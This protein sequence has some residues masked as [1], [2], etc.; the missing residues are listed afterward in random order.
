MNKIKKSF[1]KN[2][3]YY[4]NDKGERVIRHYN[5][6]VIT[7]TNECI[8]LNDANYSMTTRKLVNMVLADYGISIYGRNSIAY[9]DTPTD[10]GLEYV[11]NMMIKGVE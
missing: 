4:I 1:V 10:K 5:S 11:D 3:W 8:I 6:D 9:I 7:F 2:S